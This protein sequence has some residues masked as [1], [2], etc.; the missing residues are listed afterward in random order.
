MVTQ[1]QPWRPPP[2]AQKADL[3]AE[4]LAGMGEEE[5]ALSCW[6]CWDSLSTGETQARGTREVLRIAGAG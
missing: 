6:S 5:D 1:V 4:L 2:E 3:T